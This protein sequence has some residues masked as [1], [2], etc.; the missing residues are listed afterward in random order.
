MSACCTQTM[1]FVADPRY[2]KLLEDYGLDGLDVDYEYP[3]NPEQAQGYVDLL[4]ELRHGL[5]EHARKKGADYRFLLTV[6]S[7]PCC[8]YV[9]SLLHLV[10]CRPVRARQL[11]EATSPRDGRQLGYVEHDVIR[12]CRSMGFYCWPSGE[13]LWWP[14]QCRPGTIIVHSTHVSY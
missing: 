10:D 4:R 14:Y 2:R 9:F 12:S 1:P 8:T 13:S 11:P 3:Q 7:S 5:D 6:R